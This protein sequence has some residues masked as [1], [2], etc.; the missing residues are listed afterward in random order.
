MLTHYSETGKQNLTYGPNV[1]KGK[2]YEENYLHDNCL[3][4]LGNYI[5]NVSFSDILELKYYC[6]AETYSRNIKFSQY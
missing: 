6:R 3:F 4:G 2:L 5:I 1:T